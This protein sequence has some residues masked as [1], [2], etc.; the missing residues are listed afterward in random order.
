M[1]HGQ[2]HI[3]FSMSFF[4]QELLYF[5]TLGQDMLFGALGELVFSVFWSVLMASRYASGGFLVS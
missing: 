3:E 1:L 4:G 5:V 2:K